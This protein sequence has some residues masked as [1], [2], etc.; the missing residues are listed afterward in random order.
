MPRFFFHIRDRDGLTA[1]PDGT[2]LPDLEAA[3]TEALAAARDM[4]AERIVKEGRPDDQ[5]FE[6]C[7][8]AGRLLAAVP[9]RDA[10][11]PP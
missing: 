2:D 8:E 7:D 10:P 1:D 6:T 9:F 4:L 5:R 11:E 3:R